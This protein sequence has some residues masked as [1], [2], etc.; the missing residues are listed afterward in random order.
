M[1]ILDAQ[2]LDSEVVLAERVA[3]TEFKIAQINE[4]VSGRRV[5]VQ[6]ELGPFTTVE[7]PDGSTETRASGRRSVVAWDNEDY[8]AVRDTWTNADLVAAVKAKLAA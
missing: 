2:T 6:V 7:L 8:D 3:T 5:D 4:N 1:A